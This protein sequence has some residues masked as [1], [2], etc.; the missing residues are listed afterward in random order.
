MEHSKTLENFIS[1]QYSDCLLTPEKY[2][3]PNYETLFNFWTYLDTLTLEHVMSVQSSSYNILSKYKI[4]LVNIAAEIVHNQLAIWANPIRSI[5]NGSEDR[6]S[7]GYASLEIV[8]VHKLF[9]KEYPL[10]YL[11]LFEKL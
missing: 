9:D 1:Q 3:G 7:L 2:F 8:C 5:Y 10:H 11:P 4:P 6:Y